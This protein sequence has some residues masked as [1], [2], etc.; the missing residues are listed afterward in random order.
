LGKLITTI[1]FPARNSQLRR[2]EIVNTSLKT[3]ASGFSVTLANLEHKRLR[4]S[5]RSLLHLTKF[6]T[7]GNFRYKAFNEVSEI[8]DR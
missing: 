8:F 5:L 1:Q 4:G 6:M 7:R 2:L 3:D